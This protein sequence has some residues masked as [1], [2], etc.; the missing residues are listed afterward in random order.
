MEHPTTTGARAG[1][2]TLALLGGG[3]VANSSNLAVTASS[4][5]MHDRYADVVLELHNPGGRNLT[6]DR[7]DYELSHGETSFPLA[8]GSWTGDIDLPA[9]S[10]ATLPLSITFDTEPIEPDSGLLHLSGQLHHRD[11]TGYL[12]L[13]S[14]DLTSTPF[15]IDVD[16]T[17]GAP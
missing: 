1:L 10:I 8:N 15:Q 2:V 11:R 14:M 9:G 3:C 6:I 16:A 17:R 4:A 12:G 13:R 5:R 7:L